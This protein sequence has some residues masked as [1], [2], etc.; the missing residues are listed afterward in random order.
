MCILLLC[1]VRREENK[2]FSDAYAQTDKGSRKAIAKAKVPSIQEVKYILE[3]SESAMISLDEIAELLEI[4]K[5]ETTETQFDL[6]RNFIYSEFRGNNATLRHIAPVYLSS[7]CVDACG[8][9]NYSAKRKDVER[10]RLSLSDLEEE[11]SD[12]LAAE[13]AVIEFT[14]ATDPVFTPEKLV[15]YIS[16]TKELLSDKNGSGILLC[17]DYFSR[18]DYELLKKAGLWGLV[19]W[20]ETLDKR[21]YEK[22]HKNSPR[23][24]NFEKR[25]NNHD[26]A[27]Q[28]G[29][30]VATG[31]LFGL[32]DYRYDGLM[33]IAKARYLRQ[34]Y[35]V[36]PFVFGTPRLKA[37]AGRTLPPQDEVTDMQYEL[38]LMVYKLAEPKIARWLQTRETPELNLRNIVEGDVYTYRCGDVK[39]GGYKVNKNRISSCR[40]GQFGVAE[41]TKAQFKEELNKMNF[42]IDYA[43]INQYSIPGL[44]STPFS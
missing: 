26:A 8:Y 2:I 6:I 43:W 12:V 36:N 11:L 16:R 28:A 1:F 42:H 5:H 9:C 29:L 25:I 40:G 41:M 38:A 30:Q 37:I 24:S 23:K 35:G 34:E 4:G 3:K 17:S 31:C 44:A 21:K 15:E 32:S 13:S 20:D 14:L 33:Q 19:Q 18:E 22:W 39:P 10:V 7:F 27:I